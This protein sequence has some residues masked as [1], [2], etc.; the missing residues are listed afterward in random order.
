LATPVEHLERRALAFGQRWVELWKRFYAHA[1]A[2]GQQALSGL[3]DQSQGYDQALV[4]ERVLGLGIKRGS[5]TAANEA[6]SR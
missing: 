1:M 3:V 5:L 4:N 2:A 6:R